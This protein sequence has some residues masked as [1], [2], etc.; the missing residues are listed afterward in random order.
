MKTIAFTAAIALAVAAPAIARAPE[1]TRI[2][3]F[4]ATNAG[5]P[6]LPPS[7]PVQL[8]VSKVT[9]PA[10]TGMAPHKHPF[11]RIGYVE[12][13]SVRVTNLDT[14]KVDD[15]AAGQV[16][17]EARDQWHQGQALGAAPVVLIVFDQTPPGQGN[18]VMKP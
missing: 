7:G 1:V 16:I 9:I 13:G 8:T 3:Q 14:G 4:D 6:I 5:Q 17:V 12:S 15:Y 11:Q 18:M 10:G 2:G